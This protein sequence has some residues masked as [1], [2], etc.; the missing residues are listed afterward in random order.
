[1]KIGMK[2]NQKEISKNSD[3]RRKM[4]IK[5]KVIIYLIYIYVLILTDWFLYYI[6]FLCFRC[7]RFL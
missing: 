3:K 1:M 6:I 7:F 2:E 5:R 4:M